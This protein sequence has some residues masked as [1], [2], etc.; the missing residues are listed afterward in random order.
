MDHTHGTAPKYVVQ[1]AR[2]SRFKP[3]EPEAFLWEYLR[4]RQFFGLKF[5]RQHPIGRYIADF[6]CKEAALV[7]EL[8]GKVH[9]KEDQVVYDGIRNELMKLRGLKVVRITNA[10]LIADPEKVLNKIACHITLNNIP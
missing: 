6:F 3:T 5:R 2:E 9:Q 1:L 7:V 10:E 8:D 4:D